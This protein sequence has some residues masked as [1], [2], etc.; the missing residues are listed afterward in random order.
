MEVSGPFINEHYLTTCRFRDVLL[1][2]FPHDNRVED[3]FT[4]TMF[5]A[6]YINAKLNVKVALKGSG[7]L[8]IKLLDPEM[9]PVGSISKT[10]SS[11][12]SVDFSLP[13][14]DPLKWT[15]ESPSLYHLILSFGSDQYIAHHVGF[16]QVEMIDGLIKVNGKRVRKIRVPNARP[17]LFCLPY[18][19]RLLGRYPNGF[20]SLDQCLK[21]FSLCTCILCDH[22]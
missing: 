22:Y 4:Q 8:Q 5:D 6:D 1:V 16:R 20:H 18:R 2:G 10:V 9:K 13:V 3:L 15:A 14:D 19:G 12:P 21:D 11:E 17:Y 7:V